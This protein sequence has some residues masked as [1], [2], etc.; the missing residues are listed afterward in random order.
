MARKTVHEDRW[1]PALP[2]DDLIDIYAGEAIGNA[3]LA[4]AELKRRGGKEKELDKMLAEKAHEE[5]VGSEDWYYSVGRHIENPRRARKNSTG[6]VAAKIRAH[7]NAKKNA[8]EATYFNFYGGKVGRVFGWGSYG[9]V[10]RAPD[11]SIGTDFRYGNNYKHGL[12]EGDVGELEEAMRK[13]GL[14]WV[15]WT[16]NL[17][18][19]AFGKAWSDSHDFNRAYRY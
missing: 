15:P 2:E 13:D 8:G 7:T 1:M 18:R 10:Y 11:G 3:D 14:Q 4:L 17:P 6:F 19:K 5:Y 12:W 9:R 16:Y